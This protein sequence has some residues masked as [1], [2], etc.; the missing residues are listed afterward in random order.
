VR[1]GGKTFRDENSETTLEFGI[2][3]SRGKDGIVVTDQ[4]YKSHVWTK[5]SVVLPVVLASTSTTGTGTAQCS[6]AVS[7]QVQLPTTVLTL[8][9]VPSTVVLVPLYQYSVLLASHC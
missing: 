3:G 6:I 7:T 4:T 1:G 5:Y 9:L 2:P 8:V